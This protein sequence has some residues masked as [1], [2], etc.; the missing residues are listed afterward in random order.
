MDSCRILYAAAVG[1]T[2][3]YRC[4]LT[5]FE[6]ASGRG[7]T[8]QARGTTRSDEY[9]ILGADQLSSQPSRPAYKRLRM[10]LQM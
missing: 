9:P 4:Q 7:R 3:A 6:Q 5:P 10:P 2:C 8:V 1:Q